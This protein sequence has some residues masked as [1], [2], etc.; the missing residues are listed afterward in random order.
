MALS[1]DE[2]AARARKIGLTY[3]T[4]ED[5][6]IRRRPRGKGFTYVGASGRVI[7]DPAVLARIRSLAIPPAYR[8]VRIARSARAH[9]QAVGQDD[10][11]RTQYRYHPD[12]T[13]VRDAHKIER[14]AAL[15]DALP[16]IRRHISR[17]VACACACRD[18][19]VSG[20]VMLID[21]THIRIGCEDYVHS[22]RA[23]GAATLLK[24][25]VRHEGG[26]VILTFRG[27]GGAQIHCEATAPALARAIAA[28]GRL[29]GARLF[30]Y[31][32]D[33]GKRTLVSAADANRFL[34]EI[35]GAP[36]T[37]KDFRTLAA[38]AAAASILRAQD[39]A[40]SEAGRRR[41]VVA[42]MKEVAA[43]LGNTP[44]VCRKSYVHPRLVEAFQS[45]ELKRLR[46]RKKEPLLSKGEALVASLFA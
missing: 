34:Q 43:M 41:Q 27:K 9:L 24:R 15:I 44:A 30:Q 10:A 7:R 1:S 2:L 38:T 21:K 32:D 28:L 16:R 8:D 25:N 29:P 37:A 6:T 13:E 31:R 35:S 12:W 45:G 18:K 42:V 19:A 22:G 39:P 33:G 46:G 26:K 11:G 17:G 36:V 4:P 23:R 5:L 20:V 14:L 3:V 40:E